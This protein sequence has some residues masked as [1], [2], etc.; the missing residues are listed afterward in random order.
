MNDLTVGNDDDSKTNTCCFNCCIFSLD[1]LCKKESAPATE[2][3]ASSAVV[4][5]AQV[6]PEQQAAIDAIDQ[7]ILDEGNTDIPEDVANAPA[8]VATAD[9]E[10]AASEAQ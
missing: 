9:T 8:D 10:V 6:T 1:C 7:P 4:D 3:D 2:T 5:N